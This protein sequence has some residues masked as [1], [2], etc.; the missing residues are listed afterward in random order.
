VEALLS[1]G[2]IEEVPL[3]PSPLCY[4]S[5]IFLVPKKSGGMRPIL[6]LKRLNAAHLNTPYFRMETV[7]DV[8][9]ALRLGD[10]AASIDLRD[11][12]F[13]VLLHHSTKKYMCF[14]WRGH[15]YCFCVLP[16]GLSPAPKVFTALTR[17]IKAKLGI[18]GIR[19][20]FY[21]DYILI[22]GSTYAICLQ[23]T[24]EALYLLISASFVIHWEKSS[25][26]P[27][28]DFPFLGFQWNTVQASIAIPQVKVDAL[29]SQALILS[30]LTSSTCRQILVLT[31]LIAAFF[32][33]VLLLRLKGRWLQISLNSVY[34]SE[35][36]LQIQ[37]TVILSPQER[38]DL[39]WII[40]LTPHQCFTPFW[41]L[42]PEDCN[43]EVQT[44]ASK[45]GHGIWFQGSL[46]QGH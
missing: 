42:S 6:N 29:R 30:N 27:S 20:V 11:A 44:G 33:A 21:I 18:Q 34:S 25:L 4:I 19:T 41:N 31:G 1:K 39:N 22:L 10:W 8:R 5:S 26:T 13:H 38:R 40:S 15:L 16:F 28:T 7:E 9:H 36:D 46:H 3:F 12:Y 37:K 43:L 17:F 35:L 2:A 23:N 45:I 24:M 32:K 14:E